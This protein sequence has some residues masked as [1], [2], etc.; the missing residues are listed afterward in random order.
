[1]RGEVPDELILKLV[2]HSYDQ[3]AAKLPRRV[4]DALF[5]D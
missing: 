2:R 3:A 4:R 1:M 5:Q